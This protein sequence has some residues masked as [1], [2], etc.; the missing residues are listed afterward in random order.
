MPIIC[1]FS[2]DLVKWKLPWKLSN[3]GLEH[4]ILRYEFKSLNWNRIYCSVSYSDIIKS[5]LRDKLPNLL[6]HVQILPIC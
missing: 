5:K 6:H 2:G 1:P 4:K 3:S